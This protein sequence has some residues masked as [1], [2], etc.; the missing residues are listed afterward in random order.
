MSRDS[1]S[2][3]VVGTQ[4]GAEKNEHSD[5]DVVR[6]KEQCSG[7]RS[8]KVVQKE[9]AQDET[10]VAQPHGQ[11]RPLKGVQAGILPEQQSRQ[12]RAGQQYEQRNPGQ[13]LQDEIVCG[14]DDHVGQ[15]QHNNREPRPSAEPIPA[16]HPS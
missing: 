8:R 11:D 9:R 1:R 15:N 16:G 3:G 2:S 12:Q 5:Q 4:A 7:E 10:G 13:C 14:P 6:G